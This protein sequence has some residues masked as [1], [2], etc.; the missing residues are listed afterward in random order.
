VTPAASIVDV[1]DEAVRNHPEREALVDGG[2]RLTFGDVGRRVSR[3]AGHLEEAGVEPG[4][5]VGVCLPNDHTAVV[6][7]LAVVALGAV[8]VG[9]NPRI[10][11]PERQKLIDATAAGTLL[12]RGDLAA[13]VY[14]AGA[15]DVVVDLDDVDPAR[16]VGAARAPRPAPEAPAVIAFTSGTT[17]RPRGIVHSHRNL[18]LPGR[19]RAVTRQLGDRPRMGVCLPLSIANVMALG[20]LFTL[21]ARATCVLMDSRRALDVAELIA[22][23]R[24]TTV[25]LPPAIVLDLV[26]D[27]AVTP[28]LLRSME[29]PSTGGAGCSDELKRDF[30]TKFGVD[31]ARTYGLTELPTVA[32]IEGWDEPA[33]PGSSGRLLPYLEA[34]VVDDADKALPLGR[35]GELCLSAATDGEWA[36]SYRPMLGEWRDGRVESP[37]DGLLR[38]GDV[39]Y[40]DEQGTVFVVDRRKSIINRGGA[41][42]S[43]AEVEQVLRH[44]PAV[45]QCVVLGVPDQRLGERVVALVACRSGAAVQPAELQ[46]LC[47]EQLARYKVPGELLLVD[48]LPLN[49]M[50]K[51][52]RAASRAL[53]ERLLAERPA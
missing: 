40:V 25:S 21:Q 28:G 4:D 9:L 51:V 35:T 11:V 30:R 26:Q 36:G 38:T 50:E 47:G 15:P 6:G 12:T 33:P 53:L 42:V 48:D 49:A 32:A 7:F 37:P 1:L 39:G 24:V 44:H 46:A 3:L 45:R 16:D 20:P 10:P 19:Y 31:I 8:W 27:P 5:R 2:A 14:P 43:P 41:N 17:G 34:V 18:L 23:E 52:D 22:A 13:G 29:R